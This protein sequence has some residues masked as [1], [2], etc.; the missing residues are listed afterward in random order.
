MNK[1][2]NQNSKYM[3]KEKDIVT[4]GIVK[5]C[6]SNDWYRVALDNMDHEISAYVS[7][8]MRRN[9]I[10]ILVGDAV[11]VHISRYNP[12]KGRISFRGKKEKPLG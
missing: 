5:E 12:E 1:K 11:E 6:L 2:I 8:R 3:T 10:R 7:G 9:Q 4:T